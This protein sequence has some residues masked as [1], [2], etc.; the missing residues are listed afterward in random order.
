MYSSDTSDRSFEELS[1]DYSERIEILQEHLQGSERRAAL[2]EKVN[3]DSANMITKLEKDLIL[4]NLERDSALSELHQYQLS[5]TREI[6]ELKEYLSQLK[7]A[8][9]Q[10]K[11][12][13]I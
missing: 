7:D 4:A 3:I 8:M 11:Q 5:S 1:S 9:V 13:C 10:L 2:L 6:R 12:V